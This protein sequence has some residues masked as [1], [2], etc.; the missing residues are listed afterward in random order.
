MCVCVCVCVCVCLCV[1]ACGL[2][3]VYACV[4]MCIKHNL[5]YLRVIMT[6]DVFCFTC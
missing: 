1:C 4:G 6:E 3:G 5:E 2:V